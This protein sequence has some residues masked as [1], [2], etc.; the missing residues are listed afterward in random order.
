MKQ[1]GVYR[2]LISYLKPYWKQAMITYLAVIV[3]TA[4]KLYV[5]QIIKEAIDTGLESG[6]AEALYS[7]AGLILGLAILLGVASFAMVYYGLWLTHVV[8]Y[9]FRNQ[10]Y[11][12]V[13]RLPFAFHDQAQTGDLMS[14][15][16]ADITETERFM[17]MGLRDLLAT[18]LLIIG[19][20]VAMFREDP[21]VALLALIPFPA[22]IYAAIRFGSVMRPMIKR[23]QD[24][25]GVLATTM[26]ESMT[27]IG[28][29]KA[30]A[31]EPYELRKFD[32]ENTAWF[33]LRY[34]VIRSWG[35]NW[36]FFTFTLAVSIFLLLL[37]GG[38][39][40]ISGQITIGSLFAMISYVLM[41]NGPV[42]RI[43][44]LINM[45]STAG[46]S[47]GRVFE[48]L[49][50]P[51]PIS[52]APDALPLTNV[53]GQV[54]FEQVRF[55]YQNGR[56]V[57]EDIDFRVEP[58]QTIALMGLTGSGKSTLTNLIPRFYDPIK[59]RV[60]V[61]G[62]DVRQLKLQSLREKIGIVLQ[63]SFLF[64]STIA[65][66]IAY[67]QTDAE[68]DDIIAAAKTA[69]AHDFIMQFPNGYDTHVGERGVTLSGGQKQRLA[70]ARALLCDPRILILDD[71][72]SS[73]DTETEY[74]IQQALA[75]LMEGRTTFVIAQRLLT[76]KNADMILVLD[77]GRIVERGKHEDLLADEGLYRQIYDL[78]LKDQEEM[79]ARAGGQEP[80]VI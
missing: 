67:G 69:R 71:S 51:N 49:D 21:G 31:R 22:F 5:P 55:A 30:F 45:A 7:A 32:R 9:D 13:Q 61:D 19:V 39:K 2:R 56:P 54:A 4:L 28:V 11:E 36:P 6:T 23:I 74:L 59:G 78:Q 26:Q 27:G 35:N 18:N 10:F 76:L 79:S 57:L 44:F 64:S 42:M 16:T 60:L 47:A 8:A 75:V 46:A 77:Q 53:R 73:V 15:A 14:R 12:A 68:R 50:T 20:I 17:G 34:K 41:L 37:F 66:N 29:V 24:Q 70:I 43:G 1:P 38:P 58:G 65:E 72:T 40:A 63:D 48:I 25:M 80:V 3:V 52:E 33:D 62:H